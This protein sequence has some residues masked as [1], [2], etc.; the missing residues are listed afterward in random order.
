[1]TRMAENGLCVTKLPKDPLKE[2]HGDVR[3]ALEPT[4]VKADIM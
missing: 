4:G 2:V 3:S 1:M